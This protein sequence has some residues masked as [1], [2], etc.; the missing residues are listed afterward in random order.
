[1]C[2]VGFAVFVPFMRDVIVV[3]IWGINFSSVLLSLIS[4]FM[5]KKRTLQMRFCFWL[6]LINILL[7][8]LLFFVYILARDSGYYT[9]IDFVKFSS[10]SL[11]ATI[12]AFLARRYIKKDEDL[13]RSADRIR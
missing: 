2:G 10:F 6:I 8:A 13:V 1:M 11:I 7:I 3:S 4:I 12:S 5:F 9:F